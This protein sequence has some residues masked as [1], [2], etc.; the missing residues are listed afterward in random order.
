MT[1]YP[2]DVPWDEVPEQDFCSLISYTNE[3][4]ERL[5]QLIVEVWNMDAEPENQINSYDE[6]DPDCNLDDL[7]GCNSE[8]DQQRIGSTV[9]VYY[10]YY[11]M[12]FIACEYM[13]NYSFARSSITYQNLED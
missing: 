5:K 1:G 9:Q 10:Y 11:V 8:L 2:T 3:E 4:V 7:R 12:Y 6:L 13:I